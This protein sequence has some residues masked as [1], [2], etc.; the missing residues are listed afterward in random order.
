[1]KAPRNAIAVIILFLV[2]TAVLTQ[3]LTI[4]E[5]KYAIE[6]T[7]NKGNYLV[8][9]ISLHPLSYF[10]SEKRDFFLRTLTEYTSYEGLAYL[11]VH[12]GAGQTLVSLAPSELASRI[13]AEIQIDSINT[14]GLFSQKFKLDG[15]KET[16]HEFAKP[17][18]EKGKK[19]GTVRLG[20]RLPHISVFSLQRMSFLAMIAFFLFTALFLGYWGLTRALTP[21]KSF[22]QKFRDTGGELKEGAND[23][24]DLGA[25]DR[26]GTTGGIDCVIQG[27]DRSLTQ[28][29]EKMNQIESDNVALASKLGVIT[30]EKNQIINIIDSINFGM[31]ITDIQDNVSLINEYMLKLLKKKMPEVLDRALGEVL[32]HDEINLFLS[33]QGNMEHFSKV[34]DIETTFPELAPGEIFQVS[35]SYLLDTQ[36][37][38]IGKMI[39]VKN[40]TREKLEGE[41]Q[42]GFIAHVAHE[43][44]TPLTNIKSYSEMLMEGEIDD[45]EMQ[46]EFYNTINE[47]T[48]RLTTLIKNLLNVSK[49]EM[50]SLMLNKGLVRTDW[51][52]EGCLKPIE[53]S[54]QEK[55]ISIE[56]NLPDTFPSL[57]ADKELL[58]NAIINILGN[59]LKYTPENGH[60]TF[61]ISAQ[62]DMVVFEITDD[63]YGISEEDLPHI[64]Q[65]FYRASDSQVTQQVGSGLGLAI[66]SDIVRLHDGE[67]EVESQ[68]GKGSHFTIRIPKEEYHI[69]KQ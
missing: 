19:V 7:L 16:I 12:D 2:S 47:E 26:L 39:S 58:K 20:L 46:K 36:R 30:F 54:A 69:G 22:G 17:I 31:I 15:S 4:Q 44:L 10:D 49:M 8:S 18:F 45:T 48:N 53:A 28:I 64:F 43:L 59:A 65:K 5:R 55:N 61:A 3:I 34:R 32:E 57:L 52:V 50:G 51:F 14:M 24:F 37:T 62:D 56:K 60:I 68:L 23:P 25:L 13:P 42:Q 27:L 1:M 66:T 29:R 67:I 40:I 35:C 33:Q 41:A 9:L 38:P 11:F 6:D 21:L 63:G